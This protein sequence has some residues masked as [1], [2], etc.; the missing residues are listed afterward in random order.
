[1]EKGTSISHYKIL[2]K[3]G[4]GGM[5]VVYKAHDRSLDRIV[6]IK[7][8]SSFQ[9]HDELNKSRFL[10]EARASA[11]LSHPNIATVYEIGEADY[12]P[13][14]VMDF[15]EGKTLR[16]KIKE[17]KI[18]IHEAI[19]IALK[20]SSGLQK[21]HSKSI[22]HRD[23]KP[24]NIIFSEDDELK[25]ID[26]GLAK[27]A[28]QTMLTK[29]G[30]TLGTASYMSPEQLQGAAVDHRTDIWA[31]GVL[32]YEILAG[33][34]PFQGEYEQAIMYSIANEEPEY[35]TKIRPDVPIRVEKI[36]NKALQKHPEK[37]YQNMS[38]ML[39]D[40]QLALDEL[41]SGK[42]RSASALKLSRKQRRYAFQSAIF[43]FVFTSLFLFFIYRPTEQNRTVSIALL[44]LENLSSSLAQ[45]WFSDGMT[46]ALITD[47][48]RISG[49]RIIARSSV[50]RYKE[51]TK[52]ASE[53]ASELGV[54]YIIEGAVVESNNQIRISIRLIDAVNDEYLWAQVYNRDLKN[55][56]N[57][58]GEVAE[59]IA[60]Q[61][62]VQVTPYEQNLLSNRKDVN[63]EAYEAYLQGNYQRWQL[64]KQSIETALKYYQLAIDIDPDYAPA[65]AGVALSH[66]SKAQ[67][68]YA[69]FNDVIDQTEKAAEK[70][71][72]ID[73]NLSEIHYMKAIINT[74]VYWDWQDANN[75]FIRAIELNP[76]MPE[77]RAF[78][79]HLLF[80]LKKPNEALTHIQEAVKLDP[81][82]PL[83]QAVYSM[84]LMYLKR[85]DEVISTMESNL[86][87]SPED[88]TS[89]STL[90]SAY[91][92]KG[93]YE[94]AIETWKK[95]FEVRDDQ[96]AIDILMNAY[97]QGGYEFALQKVAEL[98]IE[99]SKD[100][101]ITPW[102]I[103]TLYTRAGMKDEALD[104]LEMAY[105]END[106]NMP[107]AS[108]DPI[109]DYMRDDPRFV[110]LINKM[111]L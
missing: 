70:A 24:A 85:Y 52:I 31:L 87:I 45:D 10:R 77:A 35:I 78:Y 82:N 108:V 86:E 95:S 54:D 46:D 41:E 69:S 44:P 83:F 3:L 16:N 48:A 73:S 98:Y 100:E 84:D 50:M 65:Y 27:F 42:S 79:S 62:Q 23:I 5:G 76:N 22:I 99:R 109:F 29:S 57:L 63:P 49:L 88:R 56:L 15:Y 40:L 74:W 101:Y 104:Y 68:G 110:A 38:D 39:A 97:N 67:S 34:C 47:L 21:A 32:L 11:A 28:N 96:E 37:R 20:I 60:G 1:M 17:Q 14:I 43:L 25:I 105:Q 75:E 8:L 19:K 80:Y 107:Y 6:A 53:I 12:S 55:V 30:T 13:F 26:F 72:E 89:L 102:Q 66:L 18:G 2:E 94:K 51:T 9:Q 90:R 36:I 71:L 103:G 91:H 64:T 106:L 4:E 61:I 93:M 7:F 59:A 111:G 92:Q 81:Y 58:Q 33:R